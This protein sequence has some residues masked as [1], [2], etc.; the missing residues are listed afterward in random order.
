MSLCFV[1]SFCIVTAFVVMITLGKQKYYLQITPELSRLSCFLP[2]GIMDED[3][4]ILPPGIAKYVLCKWAIYEN[5]S[6][7][8][9]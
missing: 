1:T 7:M 6:H 2:T 4:D 5:C 3:L 8:N 9:E